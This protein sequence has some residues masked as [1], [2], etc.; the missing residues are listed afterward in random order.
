M[1]LRG[2]I[3]D[4]AGNTFIFKNIEALNIIHTRDYTSTRLPE[5]TKSYIIV[6]IDPKDVD[7]K[8]TTISWIINT[9][10]LEGIKLTYVD[11][12]GNFMSET[13]L[14][15]PVTITED[16]GNRFNWENDKQE[17][18]PEITLTMYL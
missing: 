6:Q 1:E 7:W 16:I 12:Y 11:K 15:K 2:Y 13:K 17:P 5:Y 3:V 14:F 4:K 9:I 18:Y 8:F 10:L